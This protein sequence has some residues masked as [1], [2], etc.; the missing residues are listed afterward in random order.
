MVRERRVK[1]VAVFVLKPGEEREI[2]PEEFKAP[3]RKS[4]SLEED[5]GDHRSLFRHGGARR[6]DRNEKEKLTP[7][8]PR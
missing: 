2:T 5:G 4:K 3:R 7:S 8:F 6:F 1:R